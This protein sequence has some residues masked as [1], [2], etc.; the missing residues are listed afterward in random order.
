MAAR[1]VLS[2]A[3]TLMVPPTAVA[4]APVAAATAA[5]ISHASD[6]ASADKVRPPSG[7]ELPKLS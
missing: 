3:I 6:A 7:K 2:G 4:E 1:T 5:V